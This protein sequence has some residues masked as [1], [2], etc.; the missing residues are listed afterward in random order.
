[1]LDHLG[2]A[3]N[4]GPYASQADEIFEVWK[5]GISEMA[6]LPNT[7]IK[8]GGMLMPWNGFGWDTRERPGTSDEMVALQ[9]RYYLHAIEAFGPERSMFESN[10]PADKPSVSYHVVWNAFKKM[11]AGLLRVR[12]GPHVPRHRDGGLRPRA[13]GVARRAALASRGW[14]LSPG[15][16][17]PARRAPQRRTA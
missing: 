8:L 1:M 13:A 17:A 15:R 3:L 9:G 11:V 16:S 12:E 10:F 6:S 2:T 4:T 5:Q 14:R 7:Y